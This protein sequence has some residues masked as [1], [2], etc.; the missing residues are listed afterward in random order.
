[1]D[2]VL[3]ILIVSGI[4]MVWAGYGLLTKKPHPTL[5]ASIWVVSLIICVLTTYAL[6]E[7]KGWPSFIATWPFVLSVVAALVWRH[8]LLR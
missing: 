5:R 7:A 4:A 6:T 1:M 3:L 2:F 8:R